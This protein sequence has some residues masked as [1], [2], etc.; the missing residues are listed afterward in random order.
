MSP[1]PL[2]RDPKPIAETW[3]EGRAV[4]RGIATGKAV[5]IYG[6]TRQFYRVSIPKS[7]VAAEL[8]RFRKAVAAARSKLAA[9][10]KPKRRKNG[11]SV[12]GIFEAHLLML[13]EPLL[14]P[15]IELEIR[16]Q[17]VNAEWAAKTVT[18]SLLEQY[19]A[20]PDATLRE[21][22]I[23]L[24]DVVE[25]LMNALGGVSETTSRLAKGSVIVAEE[26]RPSTLFE[27]A[28]ATP[29][30]VITENGGWT[31]HTFI[32]ARELQLPAVTGISEI[33]QH[34]ECGDTVIV[35]GYDGRV[36][37][38]PKTETIAQ[39]GAPP[40][41]LSRPRDDDQFV[42][43]RVTT[44]LDGREIVIRSN[45]D[46]PASYQ[47][48]KRLGSRG[49]GLYRTETLVNVPN[50]L[51]TEATQ[52][53]AYTA[54]AR[55]AGNDGVKIRTFDINA[56]CYYEA[57]GKREKNPALGLRAIRFG[58][59]YPKHL[60]TQLRSLLIASHDQHIDIVIPMVSGVSD[61]IE[62]RKIVARERKRLRAE[63]AAIGEPRLGAMIEVPASVL[64]IEEILEHADFLCLGTNDLVQYLTA[65]D[66]DNELAARWFTTLHPAV[67]RAIKM[68]I[69]AA[70]SAGKELVVCG[71]MAA[72]PYYVPLLIGLGARELSMNVISIVRVKKFI[73]KIAVD[74]CR[75][76]AVAAL[77]CATAAEVETLLEK[78]IRSRWPR[79]DATTGK[80]L[81][82]AMPSNI[83]P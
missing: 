55:A 10:A 37:V 28:A 66:R 61:M 27:L 69:S 21:R 64:C 39:Y 35:D 26:L 78:N 34:L 50:G 24:E 73:S 15:D 40:S 42:P 16:S 38:H 45:S 79:L 70:E 17:G 6:N 1:T 68:V 77:K 59:T 5:I 12:S 31:S 19:K 60:R 3:L 57:T 58:L 71:E 46:S 4:S 8:V 72:A 29:T 18:D 62:V 22:Y 56:E 13:D 32:I 25:R 54:I 75:E 20:I 9:L 43:G 23:D 80:S 67:L 65:T 11:D 51:P 14:C 41:T 74:E 49:I 52:V 44:T 30:A 33:L 63:S 7:G 47:K 82:V 48:A 76:L 81:V 83:A 36:I 53:A 2:S